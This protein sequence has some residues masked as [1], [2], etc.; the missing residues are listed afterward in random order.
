MQGLTRRGVL[1]ALLSGAASGAWAK[2][3]KKKLQTT[4]MAPAAADLPAP[5][6]LVSEANLSGQVSYALADL[7][8]G[9]LLQAMNADWPMPP[10]STA[11]TVTSLY[12]L[13]HLGA[14]HRFATRLMATGP[15]HDGRLE[16]DLLLVGGGDPTLTTDDLGDMAKALV[17]AGIRQV[18]GRFGVW[19]GALP[20]VEA[21][22]PEQP[23]WLGFNPA[24]CGL[25]LNFNRVNFV[26]E[27]G[28]DGYH[29]SFDARAGR[30]APAVSIAR[31][32]VEDRRTPVFTFARSEGREDWTVASVALGKSGSRWLPVRRP[33]I[34][35]GDVFRTLA[36]AEGLDLPPAVV[37]G[38]L[39]QGQVLVTHQSQPLPMVL[40]EMMKYSTNMT[41]EAVGMAAS[42]TRGIT[43]HD[44]SAAEMTRWLADRLGQGGAR[45]VD[46]SGLGGAS[47]VTAAAMVAALAEVGQQAGLAG[48]MK[49][50]HLAADRSKP[51]ATQ[52][53]VLAKTGTLN[54]VSALVGYL[55]T[56]DGQSRVFAILTGDEARRD[57]VP[58]AQKENP[59]GLRTWLARSRRLQAQLLQKWA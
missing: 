12:A 20:F 28:A 49:E 35:A 36:R 24:I 41:A 47:R 39:P 26:W 43:S 19:A 22:D 46:H 4:A 50:V 23:C 9:A 18:S 33:E 32:Q 57:A 58:D 52:A 27:R 5:E 3:K 16:G 40:R 38:D 25:N 14:E 42:L 15:L 56:A 30:Y 7:K 53:R 17:A 44:A 29:L 54:F 11:K 31:M 8:S 1:A 55:T 59:P 48:L 45:F 6:V 2:T 37:L 51:A 34:Y 13:E 21:I 10:A